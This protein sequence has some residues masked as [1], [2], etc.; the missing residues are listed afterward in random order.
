MNADSV[1]ETTALIRDVD[2]ETGKKMIN[3]YIV[4][5]ELGRGVHG[6]VK[7]CLDSETG[8]QWVKEKES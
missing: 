2:P 4:I 1:R 6:K 8:E 5:R 7:L 3:Q